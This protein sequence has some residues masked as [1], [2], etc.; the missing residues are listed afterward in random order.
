M[1]PIKK[2][3]HYSYPRLFSRVMQL[4]VAATPLAF[5]SLNAA[6]SAQI[7]STGVIEGRVSNSIT[8]DYLNLASVTLAE[9]G[10]TVLTDQF[11]YY[12]F[13]AAPAGQVTIKASYTG[14][15]NVEMSVTVAEGQTS[16]Q[17]FDLKGAAEKDDGVIKLDTFVVSTGRETNGAAIAM[18]EQHY[19]ANI[20][21]VVAVNEYNEMTSGVVT[22]V[23][24]FL[25]GVNLNGSDSTIGIRGFPESMTNVTIDGNPIASS[26]QSAESR[27]IRLEQL[28][29][30]NVARIEVTKVPTPDMPASSIGGSV[31]LIGKRA[32]ERKTPE[33]TY[34]TFMTAVNNET[35]TFSKTPGPINP[36]RKILP[37]TDLSWI[38]PVSEKFGFTATYSY[39]EQPQPQGRLTMEWVPNSGVPTNY[40]SATVENPYLRNYSTMDFPRRIRRR[41][42]AFS[43]DYRLTRKD[44][45]TVGSQYTY[46]KL[47][48]ESQAVTFDAGPGVTDFGPTF[49]QGAL[50]KGSV[51]LGASQNTTIGENF[52]AN[53]G[54]RHTGEIWKID[55]GAAF[56]WS[57]DI[58]PFIEDTKTFNATTLSLSNVTVRLENIHDRH[59]DV[60]VK[61][62]SG[63]PVDIY[64]LGSY[65]F[66][67]ASDNPRRTIDMKRSGH[68]DIGRDFFLNVP[69]TFKT[70]AYVE[71][72]IRDMTKRGARTFNYVGPDGKKG[73]ADDNAALA[74]I[75]DDSFST[76]TDP[77]NAY[78]SLFQRASATKAYD[79]YIAHPEYF[80]VTPQATIDKNEANASKWM[81]E[82]VAAGYVRFDMHLLSDRL[83][84][85]GGVRYE[86]TDDNGKGPLV[87][88]DG[89]VAARGAAAHTAYG[90]YYPCFNTSFFATE[91]LVVRTGYA[92]TISRPDYSAIIPGATVPDPNSTNKTITI[93]NTTLKPWQAD[94]YDIQV[95]YYPNKSGSLT[96]GGF[97]KDINNFFGSSITAADPAILEPYGIDTSIYNAENGWLVS[98][99]TN[100]GKARVSGVEAGLRQRLTFIPLWGKYF[101]VYGNFTQN[102]L[103]GERN[104]D[105]S[106]F[107]IRTYTVGLTFT[108]KR[109]TLSGNMKTEGRRRIGLI[110]GTGVPADTYGYGV[111]PQTYNLSGEFIIHKHL[112]VFMSAL[113]LGQR[114]PYEERY[115]PTTPGYA[116]FRTI[117]DERYTLYSLGIK[118][119]F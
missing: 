104:A 94:N 50:G 76:R 84:L 35:L 97:R 14:L 89:T 107:P 64:S 83:W 77:N 21:N 54:W 108:T 68:F 18:N 57:S 93:R 67:T 81:L 11:G 110:T 28:I 106:Q 26:N 103:Q 74:L 119:S 9:T 101:Q 88:S 62:S 15:A 66:N 56:A 24:K 30:N 5:T 63:G 29:L 70:G 111:V 19:A 80:T 65:S 42:G 113:N 31:N 87:R 90:S 38:Y 13:A 23:L 105:F 40:T 95:E 20:K 78:P 92:K 115:S 73:T 116:R 37:G 46:R 118:G 33:F 82:T 49:T 48:G 1:H 99:A 85:V 61:D 36:S 79:L 3:S 17:N 98:T 2:D 117:G 58:I 8:G 43:V 7:A 4:L 69:V 91:K 47:F 12:R 112:S 25:P 55:A 59:A 100:T 96:L 53:I 10:T 75:L 114:A 27:T 51:T 102:R 72:H 86:H 45:L 16:T 32:F 34:R 39:I 71:Q 109:L 52:Q 41:S 44:I 6:P 22:E 60:V